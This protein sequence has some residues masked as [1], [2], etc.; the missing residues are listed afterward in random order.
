MF[1]LNHSPQ[2]P[3]MKFACDEYTLNFLCCLLDIYFFTIDI[4]TCGLLVIG[5]HRYYKQ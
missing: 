1:P 2:Q 4:I 3:Q 5:R